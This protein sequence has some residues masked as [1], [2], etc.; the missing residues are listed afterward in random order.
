MIPAKRLAKNGNGDG[1]SKVGA[2]LVWRHAGFD[3][4]GRANIQFSWTAPPGCRPRGCGRASRSG[5]EG[6]HDARGAGRV[7]RGSRATA[8]GPGVFS[9]RGARMRTVFLIGTL[10]ALTGCASRDV[11]FLY[12]PNA[13]YTERFPRPSEFYAEAEKECGDTG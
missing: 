9:R 8:G 7:A 12:Y 11:T 10:L 2:D 4:R 3:R 1:L 5:P 13:P 6:L